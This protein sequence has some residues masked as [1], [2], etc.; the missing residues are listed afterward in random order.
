[1]GEENQS[2][3]KQAKVDL[4]CPEAWKGD[5][6]EVLFPSDVL[7]ERVRALAREISQA[8]AAQQVDEVVCVGLLNG[9][10]CFMVDLCQHLDVKYT[11]DFM[12]VSSYHGSASSGTVQLKKDLSFDP[13]GKH[14]LVVEDIVDTGTTL[15]WLRQYL[16]SKECASIQ[17]ACLLDK[18]E[19]RIQEN[20]AVVVEHVGFVCPNQFVVGYGLDYKQHYRGLP[21]IGVLKPQ[22]YQ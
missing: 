5:I 7:Q 16:E 19:G 11:M 17:V 9:A 21:F 1:M 2:S 4:V 22:V 14:I 18:H 15:K 8:Y 3:S 13:K 6:G 20:S 12:C 10:V